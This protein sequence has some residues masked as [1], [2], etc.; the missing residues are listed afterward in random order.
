M[1]REITYAKAFL[2]V[3]SILTYDLICHLFEPNLNIGARLAIF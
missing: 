2:L 3:A 1:G